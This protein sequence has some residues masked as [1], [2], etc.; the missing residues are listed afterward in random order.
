MSL[1]FSRFDAEGHGHAGPLRL[2]LLLAALLVL[3][4]AVPARAH[5]GAFEVVVEAVS[6]SDDPTQ[7]AY[8]IVVTFVDGHEVSGATVTVTALSGDGSETEVTAAET[9]PGVYIADLTLEPG[10]WRVTVGIEIDGAQGSVAFGEEVGGSPI[11][12]PV[13]RVDTAHPDRQGGEAVDSSVFGS[14][15]SPASSAATGLEIRVEALVRDA[16]APLIVEYGVVTDAVDAAVSLSAMSD[17]SVAVGPISLDELI[18]GVYQGRIEYP[19]AGTWEVVVRVDG[20]DGGEAGFAEALP[21]PHYTTEAGSPKI[22]VDSSDPSRE[23]SLIDI[24]ESP[25]FAPTGGGTTLPAPA[26]TTGDH[27]VVVSIPTAGSE[28]TFQVMLRWLHLAGIGI[29]GASLAVIGLGRR[30]QVWVGLAVGGMVAVVATGTA[31]GLW[32]APTAFPGILSWSELGD[33]VYGDAYRW[34]FLAKMGFVIVALAA[35]AMLVAR[36]TRARLAVTAAGMLGAL[37]AV[38]VMA[39]LHLFAHL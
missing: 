11:I 19:E 16:V 28:V 33:R 20:P 36:S 37:A 24:A 3:G 2:T 13:V 1:R 30:R 29:W 7:L 34:A 21:W 18:P 27:D 14:P 5:G 17:R 8:G 25:I 4:A 32:G 6:R 35:T 39:Q 9:T 26:N 31:L 12:Q 15:D 10:S 23:G 22:K 38:V